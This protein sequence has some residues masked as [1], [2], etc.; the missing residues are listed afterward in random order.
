M[1]QFHD[2]FNQGKA[3]ACAFGRSGGIALPEFIK[4]VTLLIRQNFLTVVGKLNRYEA[5]FA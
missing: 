3:Y 4:Q 5:L 2:S 1:M